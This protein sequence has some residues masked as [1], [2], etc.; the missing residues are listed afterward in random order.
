MQ[1]QFTTNFHFK[2]LMAKSRLITAFKAFTNPK[3]YDEHFEKRFMTILNNLGFGKKD[4]KSSID[5]GYLTN[6]YV[7]AIV[8]A[9]AEAGANIPIIIEAKRGEDV[10]VVTEGLFY[11]FVHNPNNENNYKSFC[12]ESLVYQLVTGN[13]FQYGVRGI[14]F[15]NFTERWNLAPQYIE[16]KVAYAI[17]GAYATSYRYNIGGKNYDLETEE[18]MHLKKF[19]PNPNSENP[20]MGLSPLHAGYRTLVASNEIITA[21]ASLIKNKGAIGLLSSK[22]ERPLTKEEKDATQDAVKGRIGGAKNYGSVGVT[23]GEFDF[24]KF[25]MS[26]TE[27]KILESG[28]MKLRDLCS[29]YGVSSRM[30]N[31]PNGTTFNNSK[32]DG[33]KFFSQGVLPPLE[34]D[35]DHFNKFFV[36]GWSELDGVEYTVRI[37]KTGIEALQEDQAKLIV[38]SRVRN[39]IV[40]NII[41]GIVEKKWSRESAIKQLIDALG[42][43]EEYAEELIGEEIVSVTEPIIPIEE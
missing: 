28:I 21:D 2:Q 9:I 5:E 23:S 1:L 41:T 13:V 39:E 14:G 3:G 10:E 6:T 27:L 29:I 19:N 18:V 24:I 16:P 37:D 20:T 42:V 31:D 35:L 36:K 43:E 33:K 38:K 22:G 25:A 4:L 15:N 7:Y 11:D 17:T 8:N 26:P 12:Y 32:E 40:R 30:F 34:N